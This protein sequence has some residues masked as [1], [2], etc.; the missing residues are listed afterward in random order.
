MGVIE[1]IAAAVASPGAAADGDGRRHSVGEGQAGDGHVGHLYGQAADGQDHAGMEDAGVIVGIDAGA[2]S[3]AFQ[4]QVGLGLRE[5]FL[6]IGVDVDA[7]D[8]EENLPC[9]RFLGT[10]GLQVYQHQGAVRDGHTHFRQGVLGL[11][12]GH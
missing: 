10:V 11:F 7:E 8:G 12:A 3:S 9:Q 4:Q 5:G 6:K 1:V 2:V